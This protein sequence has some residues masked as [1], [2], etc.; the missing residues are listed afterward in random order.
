MSEQSHYFDSL[1]KFFSG[2]MAGIIA[3]TAIAPIDR[4]K[5]LFMA[6]ISEFTAKNVMNEIKRIRIEEGVR[7]LWKGNLAQIIRVFPYS[8]IVITN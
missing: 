3:K 2:G 6:S 1:L 4:V 8:G 7:S 5:F